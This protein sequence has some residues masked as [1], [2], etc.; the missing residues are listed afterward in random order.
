MV[1]KEFKGSINNYR[2]K[3][4]D[5]LETI[6]HGRLHYAVMDQIYHMVI[7]ENYDNYDEIK[8]IILSYVREMLKEEVDGGY[9]KLNDENQIVELVTSEVEN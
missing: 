3:R 2:I 6:I 9:I 7:E 1:R 4:N 5:D 8:K